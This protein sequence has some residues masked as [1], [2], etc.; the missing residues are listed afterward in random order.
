MVAN[1]GGTAVRN[2]AANSGECEF[3]VSGEIV[4]LTSQ[5]DGSARVE[6]K[7]DAGTGVDGQLDNLT[8]EILG[9]TVVMG[10]MAETPTEA[11]GTQNRNS[12]QQASDGEGD[13]GKSQDGEGPPTYETGHGQ[14][15]YRELQKWAKSP[16]VEGFHGNMPAETLADGYDGGKTQDGGA[17]DGGNNDGTETD[18]L[19]GESGIRHYDEV[20]DSAPK[21]YRAWNGVCENCDNG[22]KSP[23][24][25][26]C[27]DCLQKRNTADES[28]S[29]GP[30]GDK[31]QDGGVTDDAPDV[32]P[33]IPDKHSW[34]EKPQD[35]DGARMFIQVRPDKQYNKKHWVVNAEHM[36]YN[37]LQTAIRQ[38]DWGPNK[39]QN[40]SGSEL[41]EMLA[42]NA[43]TSPNTDDSG[44]SESDT[45]KGFNVYQSFGVDSKAEAAEKV[46]DIYHVSKLEADAAVHRVTEG[47]A[48][49]V[50]EAL[51]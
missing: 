38:S 16:D 35:G 18:P 14:L 29:S 40:K 9:K 47:D 10:R 20:S 42:K 36:R 28:D 21:H 3:A 33:Q 44:G 19:T 6:I 2:R 5:R 23:E 51:N 39:T 7:I 45:G 17:S 34:D 37:D 41:A 8:R 24:A 30:D 46:A 25:L 15:T 43:S 27:W 13:N 12:G 26:F 4:Q 31:S 11:A 22:T 1:L 48:E 50:S 49:T 32:L